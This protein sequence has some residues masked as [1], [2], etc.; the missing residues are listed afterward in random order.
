MAGERRGWGTAV[1]LSHP[2]SEKCRLREWNHFR[3]AGGTTRITVIFS[4][5]FANRGGFFPGG[6]VFNGSDKDFHLPRVQ[7]LNFDILC[8]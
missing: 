1:E 4:R 7:K 2:I 6:H 5:F 3:S 8:N